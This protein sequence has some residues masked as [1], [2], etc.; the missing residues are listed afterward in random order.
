MDTYKRFE[1]TLITRGFEIGNSLRRYAI[2]KIQGDDLLATFVF[3]DTVQI[4]MS[5]PETNDKDLL[6]KAGE[7]IKK[8][9]DNGIIKNLEEYTFEYYPSNFI[10]VFN[11]LWWT[12]TLMK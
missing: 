8:S 5:H 9:I 3:S 6:H 10:E 2:Y 7:I 1:I 12:K 11:P 4:H